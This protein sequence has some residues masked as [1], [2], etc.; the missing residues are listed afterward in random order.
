MIAA[1]ASYLPLFVVVVAYVVQLWPLR[2]Q[3]HFHYTRLAE[4][5]LIFVAAA[6]GD[7][8]HQASGHTAHGLY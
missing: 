1:Y 6:V 2:Q 3:H 5:H 4:Y 7:E 8:W